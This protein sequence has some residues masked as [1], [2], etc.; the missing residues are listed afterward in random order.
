MTVINA[1]QLLNR[2]VLIRCLGVA[3]R[4]PNL[5]RLIPS[6]RLRRR[7]DIAGLEDLK[8]GGIFSRSSYAPWKGDASFRQIFD[9]IRNF[10]LVYEYRCN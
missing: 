8:Y 4:F 10:S 9:V 3:A 6:E 7:I 2:S 5:S 1:L